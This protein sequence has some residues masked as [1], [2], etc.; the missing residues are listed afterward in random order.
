MWCESA[1]QG[2][3]KC[4]NVWTVRGGTEKGYGN[5]TLCCFF[6]FDLCM[7]QVVHVD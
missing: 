6:F 4:E 2:V 7:E 3:V 5:E 1:V